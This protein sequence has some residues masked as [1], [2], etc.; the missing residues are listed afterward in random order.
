MV[1]ATESSFLQNK[2]PSPILR[3]PHFLSFAANTTVVV[4]AAVLCSS[5]SSFIG[6]IDRVREGINERSRVSSGNRS[7]WDRGSEGMAIQNLRS[8]RQ[9]RPRIRIHSPQRL[10]PPPSLNPLQGQRRSRAPR[11][12]RFPPQ[13]LR[14]PIPR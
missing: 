1:N 5:S 10:P 11:R 9:T 14:V 8:C 2:P 6:L 7:V 3:Y 12:S 13:S 4:A